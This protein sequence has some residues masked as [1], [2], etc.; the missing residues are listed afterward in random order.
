MQTFIRRAE[1]LQRSKPPMPGAL[2]ATDHNVS[3][4]GATIGRSRGLAQDFSQVPVGMASA[5]QLQPTQAR[6]LR[7]D[8]STANLLPHPRGDSLALGGRDGLVSPH[9]P[10]EAAHVLQH[11]Y[12]D[13]GEG[14]APPSLSA[15]PRAIQRQAM[16]VDLEEPSAAGRRE[17]TRLGVSLPTVS[18]RSADLRRHSD[19]IEHR[20]VQVAYGLIPAGFYITVEDLPTP[21][22]V[23]ES[24]VSLAPIDVESINDVIHDDYPS[25][26]KAVPNGPFRAK[27]YAYYRVP[28]TTVIAPTLFSP[29]TT[30]R[31]VAGM[32]AARQ[33][34]GEAG[35]ELFTQEAIG[36][37]GGKLLSGLLSRV[38]RIGMGV[39]AVPARPAPVAPKTRR[40]AAAP[41]TT[42]QRV[43]AADAT[44]PRP[45]AELPEAPPQT[46]PLA[47]RT[48][49][50]AEPVKA[51]Q[52]LRQGQA[53]PEPQAAPQAPA[54]T[55]EPA[56]PQA[57]AQTKTSTANLAGQSVDDKLAQTGNEILA[58]KIRVF[59]YSKSMSKRRW[60]KMRA[61]ATKHLYN[62]FERRAALL[63]AKIWPSRTFLEQ[64][65]LV[66]VERE[67]VL[68][69][70]KKISTS[71]KKRIPDIVE[72]NGNK[73]VLEDL[74]SSS[75]QLRS[76]KGGL[77][78]PGPVDA[79][80]R[81]KSEIAKQHRVEQEVI[82]YAKQTGGTIVIEGRDVMT[83]A[84]VQLKVSPYNVQS[85]VC[86]YD[87][88]PGM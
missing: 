28:T 59:E 67:G 19:Y 14:G 17:L 70:V 85:R 6:A 76:I 34:F 23:P 41:I 37:V 51:P 82:N 30:P 77:K 13:Q 63:R 55:K 75:T 26:M 80:F 78:R 48:G 71:G 50:P 3:G 43:P 8:R 47:K 87:Q 84:Q 44:A 16:E 79:E 69:P 36:M 66:G 57:P 31:I 4:H 5:A 73:I 52:P 25:A 38:A 65:K 32:I 62:L 64:A 49:T 86:D 2:Q 46:E 39:E 15:A 61:G 53:R 54:Q 35:Q 58:E 74:K 11:P 1:V 60:A 27:P 81:S 45:K 12:P 18:S 88:L 29:A 72:I 40:T 24:H 33:A 7:S 9:Q 10:P 21:L 42:K 20:T 22:F 83:G 56:R 68:T